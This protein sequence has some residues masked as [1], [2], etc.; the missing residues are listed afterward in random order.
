MSGPLDE[1]FEAAAARLAGVSDIPDPAE[2]GRVLASIREDLI[3]AGVDPSD[4][5]QLR[6]S[7]TRHAQDRV[8]RS[9]TYKPG[10]KVHLRPDRTVQVSFERPD[11]FTGKIGTG[12]GGTAK[13]AD[14]ATKADV[15]RTIF[16]LFRALEEHECREWF[17][18]AGVQ[19]FS[20][21]IEF[22][23]LIEAGRHIQGQDTRS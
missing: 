15:A 8:I 2:R 21:H 19:V 16:G 20:P 11:V 12:W 1:A 13:I 10:Y 7:I 23:A 9:I 17:K 3:A 6:K 4:L 14:D 5:L 22:D 18:V